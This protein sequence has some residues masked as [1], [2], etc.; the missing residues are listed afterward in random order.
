[1][2]GDGFE[3]AGNHVFASNVIANSNGQGST[4]IHVQQSTGNQLVNNIFYD[5]DQ[6]YMITPDSMTGFTADYNLFWRTDSG[7]DVAILNSGPAES[8]NSGSAMSLDLAGMQ[9]QGFEAHGVYGDPM[10]P[11]PFASIDSDPT[12]FRPLATGPAKDVGAT[13]S[14]TADFAGSAIPQGAGPDIGAFEQ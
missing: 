9:A 6:A 1:V 7:S 5:D 3:V 13:L 12:G 11:V 4:A 8:P 2:L 10:W 14:Y